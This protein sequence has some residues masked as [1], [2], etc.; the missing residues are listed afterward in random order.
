MRVLSF[1]GTPAR[2]AGEGPLWTWRP[3]RAPADGSRVVLLSDL[4]AGPATPDAAP[5]DEW[6]RALDAMPA[7]TPIV[8]SP[9]PRARVS[10]AILKRV[11]FL[12]WDRRLTPRRRRT[13]AAGASRP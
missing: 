5:P 12:H 13:S 7:P 4:G 9:Y 10:P 11:V 3:W 6:V 1:R 2:A 8:F